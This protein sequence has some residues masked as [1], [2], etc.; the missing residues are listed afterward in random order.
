M[1]NRLID[2]GWGDGTVHTLKKKRNCADM[3]RA[4]YWEVTVLLFREYK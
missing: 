2:N 4:N 3:G 1:D